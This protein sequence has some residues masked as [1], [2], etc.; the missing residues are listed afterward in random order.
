MLVILGFSEFW[1]DFTGKKQEKVNLKNFNC[2]K[3][4]FFLSGFL[5]GENLHQ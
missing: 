4:D 5:K 3:T 1:N 2:M